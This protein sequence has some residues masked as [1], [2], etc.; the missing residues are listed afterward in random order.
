MK[1]SYT[2]A[3]RTM[4]QGQWRFDSDPIQRF[5]KDHDL[6]AASWIMWII[7]ILFTGFGIYQW[8]VM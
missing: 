1:D 3:P 5:E 4:E 2:R 6:I 7:T 8:W